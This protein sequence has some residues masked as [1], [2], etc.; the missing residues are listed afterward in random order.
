[1]IYH[2]T[3]VKLLNLL[4]S[5]S[6][7]LDLASPDLS[8]HQL[9]TSFIAWQIGKAAGLE[10]KDMADLF[11]AALLHDVGALSAEEK[12]DVRMS[13][14]KFPEEHCLLGEKLL[15]QVPM[16]VTPA[17]IARC[18][19]T[20]YH[21]RLYAGLS[22]TVALLGQILMLADT[23]ERAIDRKKFILHQDQSLLAY[24]QSLSGTQIRPDLV[25]LFQSIAV[26]EDFWFDLMS[27]RL[28]SILLNHGPCHSIEIELSQLLIISEMFRNMIDFRSRFTSTHSSGVAAAAAALSRAFGFT[29][30]EIELMEVAGNLH[31]LGKMAIPNSI[32]NKPGKLTDEEFALMRQHTYYTYTILSTIGGIQHIAEWAAFHHERLDGS[33]YPFHVSAEDLSINSRIMAVA[34]IF[35]ALTEKR[36]YRASLMEKDEVLAI[37]KK[38]CARNW[39]DVNI[40]NLLEAN[41]TEIEGHVKTQQAL[42]SAFYEQEFQPRTPEEIAENFAM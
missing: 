2:K 1:M 6:D 36:P 14:M 31:D 22:P 5:L 27:P 40:V 8:Q 39:L 12:V 11:I 15:S 3:R 35:T 7:A 20:P 17:K 16:F 26:R 32:L 38:N 24:I 29:Q 18:H 33:G 30:T 28:Y 4:L 37:L 21:N 19:H 23:I 42:A 13:R 10:E 34:D 41:Y 25:E 9:R